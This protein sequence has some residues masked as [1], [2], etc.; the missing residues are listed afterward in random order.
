ME[1]RLE[2]SANPIDQ[3]P[4]VCSPRIGK[5]VM[6]MPYCLHSKTNFLCSGFFDRSFGNTLTFST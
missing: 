4:T 1:F 5:L 6:E 3:T 2:L